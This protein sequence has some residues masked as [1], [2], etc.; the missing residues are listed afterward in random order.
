MGMYSVDEKRSSNASKERVIDEKILNNLKKYAY[1]ANKAYC[2]VDEEDLIQKKIFAKIYTSND[3]GEIIISLRSNAERQNQRQWSKKRPPLVHYPFFESGMISRHLLLESTEGATK[4][5]NQLEGHTKETKNYK[6]RLVGH[7]L[8]GA[9]AVLLA[10]TLRRRFPDNDIQVYTFGQPRIGDLNFAKHANEKIY[11]I[12]RVTNAND[13]VPHFPLSDENGQK[14]FKHLGTEYWITREQ[15]CDC[16]NQ[17]FEVYRCSSTETNFENTECNGGAQI[18][19]GYIS[20]PHNGPYFGYDMSLCP[21]DTMANVE[22]ATSPKSV[23]FKD[24][25]KL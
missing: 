2:L 19:N 5:L 7:G 14:L 21:D 9:H 20:N 11:P 17:T 3:H 16:Q 15:N 12:F 1:Y 25:K 6:Y 22:K 24:Y 18:S 4:I 13:Y 10:L 23:I 8:G